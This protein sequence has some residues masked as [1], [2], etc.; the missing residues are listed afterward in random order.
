MKKII[1]WVIRYIPRKYLQLLSPLALK[2]LAL[3]YAGKNVQC[4]ICKSQF[5]KFLPY[6]RGT[7]AR[8]NA[9]CPHCQSLE[10]HRLLWLYFQEKTSLFTEAHQLL[11]I[12]PESC[13]MT[14][15][16]KLKNLEYVTADLESPL[17]QV[18]MDIHDMP[19][20]DNQ[21]SIVLCNHVMEHV[22]DDIQAMREIQR[23]LKPGGWAIIQVPMMKE[24][25]MVTYEDKSITSPA[26][27]FEAFGQEDH[28][29]MY[30]ADYGRRLEM[31]G[32]RVVEDT[33]V[34]EMEDESIKKYAL[35]AKEIIYYCEK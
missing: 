21:F 10:R 6:G 19:F 30:G 20:E 28:V 35:P 25:L 33:F 11:H 18:K 7:S 22:D 14:R 27:R 8:E 31:A 12:A 1:S 32:F 34:L 23:V 5:R 13:F 26:E 3:F 16:A 4:P 29:R 24:G 9:L 2:T 17:A 15:F